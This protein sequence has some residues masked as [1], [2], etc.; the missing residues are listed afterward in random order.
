[1][2]NIPLPNIIYAH[3][4][5]PMQ[6]YVEERIDSIVYSEICNNV[7]CNSIIR[8]ICVHN[9]HYGDLNEWF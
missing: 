3:T 2:S 9:F 6:N 5:P 1:M 4:F 8:T 7:E